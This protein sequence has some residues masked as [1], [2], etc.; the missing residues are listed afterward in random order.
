MILEFF[1]NNLIAPS[2]LHELEGPGSYGMR[3]K[4]L[5]S[6]GFH[7]FLWDYR[8]AEEGHGG[9]KGNVLFLQCHLK[10]I[11]INNPCSFNDLKHV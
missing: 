6:L 8:G 3:P 4:V 2:P 9:E 1:E 7:V 5:L 11:R 10:R